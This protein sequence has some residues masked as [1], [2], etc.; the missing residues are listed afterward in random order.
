[1]SIEYDGMRLDK[2]VCGGLVVGKES[3][4]EKTGRSGETK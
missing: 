4:G 1:M 2:G 3:C